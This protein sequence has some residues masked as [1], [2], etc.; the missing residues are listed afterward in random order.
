M[1]SDRP[2]ATNEPKYKS[3]ENARTAVTGA[4]SEYLYSKGWELNGD[5]PGGAFLWTGTLGDKTYHLERKEALLA[6]IA[7]EEDELEQMAFEAEQNTRLAE[8]AG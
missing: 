3:I 1:S 4:E 8:A 7:F 6:Q 5:H 2:L